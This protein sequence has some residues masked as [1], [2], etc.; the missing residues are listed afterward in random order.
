ME[1]SILKGYQRATQLFEKGQ[2]DAAVSV[3]FALL[4]IVPS[5]PA[6]LNLTGS[7]LFHKNLLSEAASILSSAY[8]LASESEEIC[9]NL[10]R[11]FRKTG[12]TGKALQCLR[13]S[14]LIKPDSFR[15]LYFLGEI[16][17]HDKQFE[18]AVPVFEKLLEVKPDDPELLF[19]LSCSYDEAEHLEAAFKTYER[20]LAKDPD[21]IGACI[22]LAQLYK[23]MGDLQTSAQLLHKA[24]DLDPDNPLYY[25]FILFN[26]N[27]QFASGEAFLKKASHWADKFFDESSDELPL[28]VDDNTPIRIGFISADFYKHPVGRLFFPVM[29][30]IDSTKFEIHCFSNVQIPDKLTELYKNTA[31]NYHDIRSMNDSTVTTFIRNL[32]IDILVDLSGHTNFNRLGVIAQRAAPVQIMWLGYFNTTGLKNMDYILA[33]WITVPEGNEKFYCEKVLRLADSFFPYS[34]PRNVD[35]VDSRD[36]ERIAFGCFNDSGKIND[37]VLEVWAEILNKVPNSRL[38]LKSKTFS[39]SWTRRYFI[40]RAEKIGLDSQQLFFLNS[41][42]YH[43]YLQDYGKIDI[44]LDPF[45]YSG[46]ATTADALFTGTPVLT[47]PFITFASRLSA[48]LLSACDMDQLICANLEEYVQKAITLANDCKILTDLRQELHEKFATS[49]LCNLQ[50]F[51]RNFENILLHALEDKSTNKIN[52][53]F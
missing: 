30:Q 15:M 3:C 18:A 28:I 20:L 40:E 6:I 7:I 11:V 44:C 53:K 37:K 51:T 1:N 4:K 26:L 13:K 49:R 46:G 47:C 41:S 21:H 27:Y 36:P 17:Y 9:L 2:L 25:S 29:T 45:P 14:L 52:H 22:N 34:V 16:L 33:D 19:R 32:G 39:D 5:S 10:V 8:E 12:Q 48:S 42:E 24:V 43:K 35:I 50:R 31:A 38:Y 23:S